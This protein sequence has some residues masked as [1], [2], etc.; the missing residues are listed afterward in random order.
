MALLARLRRTA[1][2]ARHKC[3]CVKSGVD[4]T[5]P[6]AQVARALK[7][8][9]ER[10]KVDGDSDADVTMSLKTLGRQAGSPVDVWIAVALEEAT[11]EKQPEVV[12]EKKKNKKSKKKRAK[13]DEEAKLKNKKERSERK[14]SRREERRLKK[15][16]KRRKRVASLELDRES[17][18]MRE[19]KGESVKLRES[20]QLATPQMIATDEGENVEITPLTQRRKE[21]APQG[22]TVDP[23][24]LID[25]L[26]E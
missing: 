4:A 7:R 12:E 11:T 21:N 23:P 26:E 8:Q 19:D 6:Q 17:T 25:A 9:R 5:T 1:R 22:S 13:G 16:E 18:S 15:E 14:E 24:I 2:Q 3:C 20:A 10:S